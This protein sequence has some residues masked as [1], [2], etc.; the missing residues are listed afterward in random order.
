MGRGAAC[1]AVAGLAQQL[2][3]VIGQKRPVGGNDVR[4]VAA[5]GFHVRNIGLHL[6]RLP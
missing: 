1:V 4:A 2:V 3:L 5:F 6:H